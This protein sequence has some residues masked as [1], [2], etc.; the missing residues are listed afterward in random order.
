[1][2][3]VVEPEKFD[4]FHEVCWSHI[5][6]GN[7]A[8]TNKLRSLSSPRSSLGCASEDMEMVIKALLDGVLAGF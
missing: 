2:D 8:L 7:T 3:G 6:T 4:Y 1:M 5:Q